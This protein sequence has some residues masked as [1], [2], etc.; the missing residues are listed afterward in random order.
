MTCWRLDA[1]N[2]VGFEAQAIAFVSA[3]ETI[4]YSFVDVLPSINLNFFP[5]DDV[6]VR[7][8]AAQTTSRN[9]LKNLGERLNGWT[10][11]CPLWET[12]DP[13]QQRVG[14]DGRGLTVKC[15]QGASDQGNPYMKPWL[16]NV[17]NT[18][19]EWYF[20]K[21]AMFAVGLFNID[22]KTSVQNFQE[23]RH[24]YDL[25]GIDRGNVANVWAA[26]NVGASSLYGLELGYKQ[27]F[28]FLPSILS[29]TG[30][31]ANYTYSQSEGADTDFLG[32]A[33]PLP[34]NSEHQSN[35]VLWYDKADL[36]VRLAVNWKSKEYDTRYGV[37][38]QTGPI[39]FGNWIEPQTYLDL[40]ASYK[41]N[42]HV[43]LTASGTNLTNQN[44]RSYSQYTNQF[45]SMYIQERRYNMGITLTL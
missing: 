43:S 31:E 24:F 4:E 14:P 26:K 2:S 37:A 12:L 8:G 28:T 34:S 27:P 33:F 5:S 22:V 17:Y 19:A 45:N 39:V 7:F 23:Q 3:T 9:D 35:L 13:T 16:A 40:S 15:V 21:N 25:D 30:I 41:I 29:A 36:N 10:G 38:T 6:I 42:E 1:S 18:S 11:D 32:E 20:D 44:K